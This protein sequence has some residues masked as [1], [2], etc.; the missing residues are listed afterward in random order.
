MNSYNTFRKK[1]FYDDILK[2][3][4]IDLMVNGHTHQYLWAPVIEGLNF[5]VFICSNQ[6]GAYFT[7]DNKNI[8]IKIYDSK[9]TI[10]RPEIN[11]KAKA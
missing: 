3:A 6:E 7:I 10:S 8:N 9:G 5:P 11:I 4:K 2:N 1:L